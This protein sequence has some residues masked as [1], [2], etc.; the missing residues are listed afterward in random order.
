MASLAAE[1]VEDKT[2]RRQLQQLLDDAR[3]VY[4]VR[5]DG[6][7]LERRASKIA[8]ASLENAVA[9]AAAETDAGSAARQLRAASDAVRALHPDPEKAYSQAIKAVE[10]AAHAVVEPANAKA[11]LGTMRGVMRTNPGAFE[12]AIPG[13]D[14]MGDVAPVIAMMTLLW[15]GQTSRHGGQLPTRPETRVEAEMAVQL[16]ATLVLWFTTGMT[17]RK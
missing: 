14:G 1:Q 10:S 11:T 7:R 15:E 3:S 13:P 17:R 2:R 16:A 5:S 4:Q 8:V 12:L 9:A 6:R